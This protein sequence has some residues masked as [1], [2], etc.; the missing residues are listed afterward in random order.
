MEGDYLS[1]LRS[2]MTEYFCAN[3][4]VIFILFPWISFVD[5]PVSLDNSFGW[6]VRIT[7]FKPTSQFKLFSSALSASASKIKGHLI[8]GNNSPI[9]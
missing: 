9:N 7:D 1:T 2:K 6:G 8:C 5:K 3:S 4:V